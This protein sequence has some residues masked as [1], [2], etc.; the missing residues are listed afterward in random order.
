MLALG[1]PA[2]SAR[3]KPIPSG[4]HRLWSEYP[5]KSSRPAARARTSTKPARDAER[6]ATPSSTSAF[7]TVLLALAALVG[8]VGLLAAAQIVRPR[9]A[10]GSALRLRRR[11]SA[12][13]A[14]GIAM[15]DRVRRLFSSAES[16][17]PPEAAAGTSPEG[18]PEAHVSSHDAGPEQDHALD[19][20]DELLP[21]EEIGEQVAAI[22][23]S[24]KQAAHRLHEAARREA[25]QMRNEANEQAAA[26]LERANAESES[27][28]EESEQLRADAR[29]EAER[30]LA[31][32][33]R[34]AEVIE[35]TAKK[36]SQELA[37]EA[38]ERRKALV[39]EAER[40]E[41]R[42]QQVLDVFRAMTS[43]LEELL[44]AGRTE[45]PASDDLEEALRREIR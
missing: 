3:P 45:A 30:V 5:V 43:Q 35:R 8:A 7:S 15:N 1:A 9:F 6:A 42:L 38:V 14:E 23:A 39:R 17:S 20:I 24:A 44:E 21:A 34:E 25:E 13:L 10:P 41:T 18:L 4:L 37:N 12:L 11:H 26:A 22:L 2:A 31:E 16:D 40:S 28:R 33:K 36:R 32:A 19:E 29:K 27:V